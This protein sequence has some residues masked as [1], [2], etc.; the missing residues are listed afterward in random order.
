M[1]EAKNQIIVERVRFL[2]EVFI[3]FF[4][5]TLFSLIPWLL[6]PLLISTNSILYGPLYYLLR[7]LAIIIAVPLFLLISNK[8]LESPKRTQIIKEDT[9][10]SLEFL[11]L[12]SFPDKSF[13]DQLLYGVLILFIIFIP[14]DFL[15][16]FLIPDML[17]YTGE[18]ISSQPTDS[19]LL[20]SYF[21][22]LFSVIIIQICVSIYEES[23][24]RGF[25][26][27]RGKEYVHKISAVIIA[28]LY[29][30]LMHFAYFLNPVSKNYP[31]WFPFI[32]FLQT[33]LVAILLSILVLK[34]KSLFPVIFAHALNNIISAHAVWNY[35]QG[36]D[37]T[38]VIYYMYI[39][40]MII[41]VVL[42]IWQ[43]STIKAGVIVVYDELRE[44]LRPDEKIGESKGDIYFRIVIDLFIGIIILALGLFIFG[45]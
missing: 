25:L 43:F 14:L 1:T 15:V 2:F 7:A 22:F 17:K 23:L 39:P 29:F 45:V 24:S 40:L 19:Y 26:T 13:K 27:M 42:L 38:L 30:G 31:F 35:L 33:F 11:K 10:P 18:T 41:G 32:W 3:I 5:I 21:V 28:S 9:N 4:G 34:K 37:F 8:A 44:Y 36:N 16:Y 20:Q 6:L 12:Y